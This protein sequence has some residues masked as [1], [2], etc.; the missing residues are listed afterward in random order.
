MSARH[1]D[2]FQRRMRIIRGRLNG[3]HF[4]RVETRKMNQAK[5]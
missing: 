3:G 2:E 1:L 4:E 5:K